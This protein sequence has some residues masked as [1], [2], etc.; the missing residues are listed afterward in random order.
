MGRPSAPATFDTQQGRTTRHLAPP[1]R[2]A[3]ATIRMYTMNKIGIDELANGL[4]HQVCP[5]SEMDARLAAIKILL[6]NGVSR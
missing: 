3:R 6:A 2:E 1:I 4:N 5:H